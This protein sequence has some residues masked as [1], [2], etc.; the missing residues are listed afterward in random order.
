M[1]RSP[2]YKYVAFR[3][4]ARSEQLFDL[5]TDPGEVVNLAADPAARPLLDSH[6]EMLAQWSR[7]TGDGFART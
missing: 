2:R 4:G 6:R 5:D 3:S 1:V 7:Q